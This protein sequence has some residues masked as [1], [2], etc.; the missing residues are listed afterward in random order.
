MHRDLT[1]PL[2]MPRARGQTDDAPW[3]LVSCLGA[4]SL[5]QPRAGRSARRRNGAVSVAVRPQ[6]AKVRSPQGVPQLKAS[7]LGPDAD[8][9]RNSCC[10]LAL[11]CV[12]EG[13]VK[14]VDRLAARVDR[15]NA[16]TDTW[17]EVATVVELYG[18]PYAQG[19]TLEVA[20]HLV[21][22]LV[23]GASDLTPRV[24]GLRRKKERIIK[25]VR[26]N[27]VVIRLKYF[28]SILYFY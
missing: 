22:R 17:C 11:K 10:S 28:S 1:W 7:D 19:A 26:M 13:L 8:T 21:V 15:P 20:R 24:S 25:T 27:V 3:T 16:A 2:L 23:R 6:R 14:H 4:R 18:G 12:L 5:A 9:T